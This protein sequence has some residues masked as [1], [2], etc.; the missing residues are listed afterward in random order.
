MW[1][2]DALTG[3]A[4]VAAETSSIK[5]GTFVVQSGS[6]SQA[7][8]ATSALSM[9]ALCR[10]VAGVSGQFGGGAAWRDRG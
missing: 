3:L 1:G 4:Y 7:L 2:H 5:R 6:P 8:L 9:A 10:A